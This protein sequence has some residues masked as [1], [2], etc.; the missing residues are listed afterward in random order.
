MSITAWKSLQEALE[1]QEAWHGVLRPRVPKVC[2]GH[3]AHTHGRN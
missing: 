3:G 2:E 1:A